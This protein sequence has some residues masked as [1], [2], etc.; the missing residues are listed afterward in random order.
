MA[1]FIT[2]VEN[3]KGLNPF[4][5]SELVDSYLTD[6]HSSMV[7]TKATHFSPEN[8]CPLSNNSTVEFLNALSSSILCQKMNKTINTDPTQEMDENLSFFISRI[9]FSHAG[10]DMNYSLLFF[11]KLKKYS[12]ATENLSL[13]IKPFIGSIYILKT[14]EALNQIS[15][16]TPAPWM[17]SKCCIS[18]QFSV[19][20]SLISQ[21]ISS[22]SK[23]K[24]TAAMSYSG[25]IEIGESLSESGKINKV[26][27]SY[28]PSLG[29]VLLDKAIELE[30]S[31]IR[32]MVPGICSKYFT[33]NLAVLNFTFCFE[34]T[35]NVDHSQP[36][37]THESFTDSKKPTPSTS[38]YLPPFIECKEN[39]LSQ[40]FF[41]SIASFNS[42]QNIFSNSDSMI[43]NSGIRTNTLESHTAA[44]TLVSKKNPI[45]IMRPG[46]MPI[47]KVG[48]NESAIKFKILSSSSIFGC[49]LPTPIPKSYNFIR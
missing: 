18:Q 14:R 49:S 23:L 8:S 46:M 16:T 42:T 25:I 20:I 48:Y 35:I 4:T 26:F 3:L 11:L 13:R 45:S 2:V 34:P 36:T 9:L 10:K 43:Y 33:V 1:V 17:F 31:Q 19:N 6:Y 27:F 37:T 28:T 39:C 44:H 22:S 41:L 47:S 30:I 24:S 32:T 15:K 40:T 5:G 29:S 7:K 12:T 21:N 38:I